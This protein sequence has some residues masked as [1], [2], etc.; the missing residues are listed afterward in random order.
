MGWVIVP[1]TGVQL[2]NPP[3]LVA[4]MARIIAAAVARRS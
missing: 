4:L 1:I 2:R 3:R